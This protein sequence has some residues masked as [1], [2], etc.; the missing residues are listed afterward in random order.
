MAS[1]LLTLGSKRLS[2]KPSNKYGY[3]EDTLV[4]IVGGSGCYAMYTKDCWH[5]RL[6]ERVTREQVLNG[7]MMGVLSKKPRGGYGWVRTAGN[8]H[9]NAWHMKNGR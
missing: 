9:K 8:I 4:R 5:V 1:D 6:E 3:W 7:L 2:K